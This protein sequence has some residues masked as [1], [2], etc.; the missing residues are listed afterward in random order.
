M[1]EKILIVDDDIDSLKLIGL[2][3]QRHGYAVMEAANAAEAERLFA[4]HS[5]A[6]FAH[7]K[8]FEARLAT[9]GERPVWTLRDLEACKL[10]R[11]VELT[12][13]DYKPHEIAAELEGAERREV[14]L[15]VMRGGWQLTGVGIAL[16]L[17]GAVGFS[18]P[19][20][21]SS[22][23]GGISA[24]VLYVVVYTLASAGTF[25]AG[26]RVGSSR[27]SN[28]ASRTSPASSCASAASGW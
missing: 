28:A 3:L 17:A 10:D 20:G 1:S 22:S 9:E 8:P 4:E 15:L 7:M 18:P 27:S 26:P 21:L 24:A 12:R 14:I 5:P 13:N 2:M 16:G 19:P 11:V 23:S 6:L 25:A